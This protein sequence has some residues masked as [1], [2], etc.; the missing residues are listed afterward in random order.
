VQDRAGC[1]RPQSLVPWQQ[2][3]ER[4]TT[5]ISSWARFDNLISCKK[6][7]KGGRT[8]ASLQ[9]FFS[10]QHHSTS[11]ALKHAIA[12]ATV[13][14]AP[15]AAPLHQPTAPDSAIPCWIFAQGIEAHTTAAWHPALHV[16]CCAGAFL[17]LDR[18]VLWRKIL[19]HIFKS[20]WEQL[21]LVCCCPVSGV[22]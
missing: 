9:S 1:S 15:L 18:V 2:V 16:Q 13:P 7:E 8:I 12:I 5:H 4:I 10:L 17:V 21:L 22:A 19:L 11:Q 3:S 6:R 14:P 20:Q